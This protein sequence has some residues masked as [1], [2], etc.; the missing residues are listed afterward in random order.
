MFHKVF[1]VGHLG[2]DPEMRYTPSGAAVTNF[3]LAT[4]RRYNTANGEPVEETI[5][6]RISVFG[7]QAESCNT[8]LKK[9]RLVLVEGRLRPDPKTGGPRIYEKN[10]GTFGSSFEVT[11]DTVRFLGGG[12]GEEAAPEGGEGIPFDADEGS[13]QI[14]F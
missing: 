5:W 2:R 14:P 1:V 3:S 4:T 6:F 9:G 7:K 8:Y 12:R 11:A 13:E 10:D